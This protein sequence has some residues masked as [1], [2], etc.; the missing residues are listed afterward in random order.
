MLGIDDWWVWFIGLLI[1]A[2]LI[3]SVKQIWSMIQ[4]RNRYKNLDLGRKEEKQ[5][6]HTS[7]ES[8]DQLGQPGR[9]GQMPDNNAQRVN[10]ESPE[11]RTETGSYNLHLQD[12][13]LPREN[14]EGF[15]RLN[16]EI[17]ELRTKIESMEVKMKEAVVRE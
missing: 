8:N 4:E 3:F 10:Q 17:S 5:E 12:M 13:A 11:H 15:Q 7:T 16:E 2:C 6:S 14:A 1:L 9:T